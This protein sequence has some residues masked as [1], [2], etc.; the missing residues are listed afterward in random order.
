MP[1]HVAIC[2]QYRAMVRIRDAV[3]RYALLCQTMCKYDRYA[4]VC[5]AVLDCVHRTTV[6]DVHEMSCM[7]VLLRM[8]YGVLLCHVR[9][10]CRGGGGNRAVL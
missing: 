7:V 4:I 1:R 5:R 9:I 3:L 2:L 6:T 10:R 8:K